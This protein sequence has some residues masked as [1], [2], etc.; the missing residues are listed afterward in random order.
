MTVGSP[1]EERGKSEPA[2]GVR[3]VIRAA[4]RLIR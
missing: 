4:N 3:R 1:Q 2:A